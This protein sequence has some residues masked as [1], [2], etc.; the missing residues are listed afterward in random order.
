MTSQKRYFFRVYIPAFLFSTLLTKLVD[1]SLT[2]AEIKKTLSVIYP[3][4]FAYLLDSAIYVFL[5]FAFFLLGCLFA[6]A[7]PKLWEKS[8][9]NKHVGSLNTHSIVF[10]RVFYIALFMLGVFAVFYPFLD[11]IS[12]S[13]NDN[14]SLGDTLESV[15]SGIFLAILFF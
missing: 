13:Y 5:S 9:I 2:L 8:P 12:K 4:W 14:F 10:D 7:L 15:F 3:N 11:L 6:D 1:K